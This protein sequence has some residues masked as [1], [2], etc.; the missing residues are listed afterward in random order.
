MRMQ[1]HKLAAAPGF[2]QSLQLAVALV[3]KF[4]RELYYATQYACMNRLP[5]VGQ[6][7]FGYGSVVSITWSPYRFAITGSLLPHVLGCVNK[8]T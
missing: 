2:L 6:W 3:P 8:T 5:R 4:T 7:Y 1:G